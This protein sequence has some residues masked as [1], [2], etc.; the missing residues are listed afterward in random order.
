MSW[1]L[2]SNGP[3]A[4]P[5]ALNTIEG[6]MPEK[7]DVRVVGAH[8]P[9]LESTTRRG[10]ERYEQLL[11]TAMALFLEKGYANVSLDEIVKASG[12]SK[13]AVYSYFGGKKELLEHVVQ[14]LLQQF[15]HALRTVSVESLS[16]ADAV[17]HLAEQMINLSLAPR[18][19]ALF[20]LVMAESKNHPE[21]G[22]I[23]YEEG[24]TPTLQVFT[25]IIAKHP[26]RNLMTTEVTALQFAAHLQ[27]AV[28]YPLITEAIA[29][30]TAPSAQRVKAVV[31]T[32]MALLIGGR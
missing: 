7:R 18:E 4:A 26:E 12:G 27:G 28:V 24:V 8:A 15:I 31:D 17:R 11:Y 5:G 16:L 19:V 21:V 2:C 3:V 29:L 13:S 30:N 1:L 10:Q 25:E 9:L 20:R 6:E 14:Q 32:S 23:W 22:R